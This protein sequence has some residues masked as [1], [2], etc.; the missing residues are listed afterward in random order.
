MDN[1]SLGHRRYE[2][3]K[4]EGTQSKAGES[5][6]RLGSIRVETNK[7]KPSKELIQHS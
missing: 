7:E 2:T 5:K 1:P 4:L 6:Y 3:R